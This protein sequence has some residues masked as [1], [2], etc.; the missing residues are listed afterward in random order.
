MS[1]ERDR[2][3]VAD[4]AREIAD[5][6]PHATEA[7]LIEIAKKMYPLGTPEGDAALRLGERKL[8]IN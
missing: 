7:E 5:E 2:A 4:A 8:A 6:H 3:L 1:I